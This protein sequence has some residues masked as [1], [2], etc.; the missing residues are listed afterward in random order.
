[1]KKIITLEGYRNLL[2]GFPMKVLTIVPATV[3]GFS[4]T[5]Y[6]RNLLMNIYWNL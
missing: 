6:V 2:I 4:L 3:L 5:E 1:M